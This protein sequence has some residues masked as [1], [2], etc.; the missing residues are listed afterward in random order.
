MHLKFQGVAQI[1]FLAF[2]DSYASRS[3]SMVLMTAEKKEQ[4]IV[5][6]DFPSRK[7]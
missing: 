5:C 4:F 3:V 7:T 6:V 1:F 2:W